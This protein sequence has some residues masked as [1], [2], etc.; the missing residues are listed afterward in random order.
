[1]SD[2]LQ[3]VVFVRKRPVKCSRR[4][5]MEEARALLGCGSTKEA[6]TEPSDK[7]K[8][9][10][11]YL[12]ARGSLSRSLVKHDAGSDCDVETFRH[13]LHGNPD[14]YVCTGDFC[15]RKTL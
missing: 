11:H 3:F 8:C 4:F 7:L 9:V 5:V 1:M 14:R 13:A 6:F 12:V 2:T 10:G 15:A